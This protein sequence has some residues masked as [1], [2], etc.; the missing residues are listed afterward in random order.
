MT[1]YTYN[2]MNQLLC[3]TLTVILIYFQKCSMLNTTYKIDQ[4]D[5]SK[6]ITES[7]SPKMLFRRNVIDNKIYWFVQ[8]QFWI[9]HMKTHFLLGYFRSVAFLKIVSL[10][11]R[12][13]I[14]WGL[15]IKSRN[16][17]NE[18]TATYIMWLHPRRCWL[19]WSAGAIVLI[20][21]MEALGDYKRP[22][23][24]RHHHLNYAP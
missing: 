12:L 16:N 8:N 13:E 11:F 17:D 6:K 14:Y 23:S 10:V 9:K 3:V 24:Y 19:I 5:I 7:L 22:K 18:L 2:L 20:K 4:S 15:L 21:I 1:V